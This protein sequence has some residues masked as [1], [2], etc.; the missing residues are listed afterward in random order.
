MFK[1]RAFL[2]A[3]LFALSFT[4]SA[5]E[6]VPKKPVVLLAGATGKN[7]SVILKSLLELSSQPY[8]VRAMTRDAEAAA[9]KFGKIADWRQADVLQPETLTP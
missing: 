7:G 9:E 5:Q 8:T 6:A 3:S 1:R 2:A 4:A